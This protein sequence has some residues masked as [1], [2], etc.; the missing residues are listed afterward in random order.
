[1]SDQ[2]ISSDLGAPYGTQVNPVTTPPLTKDP[3]RAKFEEIAVART[4]RAIKAIRVL[5]GMG[6]KNRYAYSF[7]SGD[8]EKIASTLELEVA[9]LRVVMVA[10]GRQMDIEFDL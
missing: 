1:M 9:Q 7:D 5:A 2:S 3:R 6:G 10:P 8:I 4:K